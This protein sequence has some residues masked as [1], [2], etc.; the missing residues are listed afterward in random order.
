[1]S[2]AKPN[3]SQ[4]PLAPDVASAHVN[5]IVARL[6]QAV[7][8]QSVQLASLEFQVQHLTAANTALETENASLKAAAQ[9]KPK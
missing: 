9:K 1:M 8:Q 6:Q 7:G 5:H 4:P 3:P 2:N